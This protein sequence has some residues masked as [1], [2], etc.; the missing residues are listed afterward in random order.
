MLLRT[1]LLVVCL[2]GLMLGTPMS[3]GAADVKVCADS[4][5]CQLGGQE[6]VSL[7]ND[8]LVPV[9]RAGAETKPT[10]LE[11][12]EDVLLAC[13]ESRGCSAETDL[14]ALYLTETL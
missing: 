10:L 12:L 3:H 5:E 8:T 1:G 14:L 4:W 9:L 6:L 13:F 11:R 7:A 2:A